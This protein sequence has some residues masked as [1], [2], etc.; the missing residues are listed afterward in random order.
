MK[1][2]ALIIVIIVIWKHKKRNYNTQNTKKYKNICK[3]KILFYGYLRERCIYICKMISIFYDKIWRRKVLWKGVKSCCIKF[4][5]DF[6]SLIHFIARDAIVHIILY[7]RSAL[8][9]PNCNKIPL[10]M[11]RGIFWKNTLIKA[12][13]IT[14]TDN[15]QIFCIAVNINYFLYSL[16][17]ITSTGSF[18]YLHIRDGILK[19]GLIFGKWHLKRSHTSKSHESL[20]SSKYITEN[21]SLY[22]VNSRNISLW[23][24]YI[25]CL[26][27]QRGINKPN[28]C[29]FTRGIFLKRKNKRNSYHKHS[30]SKYEPFNKSFFVRKC[31]V[32]SL[33]RAHYWTVKLRSQ[34]WRSTSSSHCTELQWGIWTWYENI[35]VAFFPTGVD[36]LVVKT[37]FSSL[38]TVS[39]FSHSTSF[40]HLGTKNR[41]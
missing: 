10:N 4:G 8:F 24:W 13:S 19:E 18:H 6:F 21:K 27:T 22:S 37:V 9:C 34:G 25:F 32:F 35:F 40:A 17:N 1:K 23:R 41:I 36:I 7:N 16:R 30:K 5:Y 31:I 2:Q 29:W 12:L 28:S 20:I 39:I 11:R 3:R 26:H 38:L 33:L 14:D 15:L